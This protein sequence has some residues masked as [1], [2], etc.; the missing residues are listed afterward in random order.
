MILLS[1][2][3]FIVAGATVVAC[4]VTA[5]ACIQTVA[6]ILAVAGIL[7]VPD[8]LLLLVSLVLLAYPD[9]ASISEIPFKF[10][11]AGPAVIGFLAVDGDLAVASIPAYPGATILAS[12][13]T[14][15]TV[16]SH[17][18]QYYRTI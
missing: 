4:G 1:S 15:W 6:G 13:F 18:L 14:Y 2:L 16:Q 3:L 7:L 10:A 11:V 17:I 5:V 8:G 12:G 9:V